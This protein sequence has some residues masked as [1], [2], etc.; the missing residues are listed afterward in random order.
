MTNTAEKQST[1]NISFT[2]VERVCK[3]N[4]EQRAKG[5]KDI[6]YDFNVMID[7]EH[8]ATMSRH[9][10][11]RGYMLKDAGMANIRK[12]LAERH[13]SGACDFFEADSQ[14]EFHDLVTKVLTLGLLPTLQQ[15]ADRKA[16]AEAKAAANEA[17]K[18]EEHRIW[19]IKE[20]G[21]EMLAA[22]KAMRTELWEKESCSG[23][24]TDAP[25]LAAIAMCDAAIELA[26][27]G[28]A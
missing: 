18:A 21:V 23:R 9:G 13:Y 16:E 26:E 25:R 7:G 6:Y 17:R 1:S 22:L 15:V 12:P 28:Q 14:K 19:L 24:K 3:H 4:E 20:A 8:R 27:K 11:K 5:G 2:R 10:Y